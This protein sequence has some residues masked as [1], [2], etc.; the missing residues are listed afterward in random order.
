MERELN[1]EQMAPS[2][3]EQQQRKASHDL[4]A[5]RLVKSK[6]F[7]EPLLLSLPVYLAQKS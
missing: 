7:Q 6:S 1:N 5:A 3:E 2:Q 4:A